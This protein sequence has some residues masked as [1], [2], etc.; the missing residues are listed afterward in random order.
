MS[1][2][3]KFSKFS[4]S[5]SPCLPKFQLNPTYHSRADVI[6]SWSLWRPSW[7]LEWNKLSNSVSSCHPNTSQQVWAHSY[8]M[9]GSRCALKIFKMAI[10][11]AILNIRTE[12]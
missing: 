3:T 12:F 5:E 6:S 4:S 10:V 11:V 1:E 7:I 8:L 2:W 9:F